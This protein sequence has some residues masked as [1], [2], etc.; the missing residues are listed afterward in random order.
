MA[1]MKQQGFDVLLKRRMNYVL[2]FFCLLFVALAGRLFVLQILWHGTYVAL[3]ARQHLNIQNTAPDRGSIFMQARDGTR[4]PLATSRTFKTLIASPRDMKSP[5][6]AATILVA[7][8]GIDKE[9]LVAKLSKPNDVYEVIARK[10]DDAQVERIESKNIKG[11]SFQEEKLRSYP[12]GALAANVVGFVSREDDIEKGR[13]GL[14]SLYENDLAGGKDMWTTVSQA[15]NFWSAIGRT[16]IHPSQNGS[17]LVLTLD[18]NIQ[19][20]A[21]EALKTVKEKWAADS[22]LIIVMDPQTGRIVSLAG[23]PS[24]DPNFYNKEKDLSVFLN[25]A[26]QSMFELGSVVKPITMAAAIEQKAVTS[27]TFYHDAGSVKFGRYTIRNFDEKTYGDQTMTQVIEK[28]LNLGMV[29]V[30]RRLGKEKE[31]EYFKR[32]G[33]GQKTGVDMMGEISG[34]IANLNKGQDLDYATAAFGQGI[35]V[36]PLQMALA[37]SAIANH[38]KLMKPY[39]VDSLRDSSGN[40]TKKYP[41]EVR[42][43]VSPETADTI[44]KMM[45]SAVREGYENKAGVSGYFIAGKTGTAQIP[46]SDGKGYSDQFIHTFVG[47]APAFDPKFLVLIQLNNPKGNRFAANTLT[48]AFHDMAQ[49]ILN[50]YEIPPD[51]KQN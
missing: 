28:S 4:V 27:T 40:E 21:E 16:I 29:F 43:V 18:Y 37:I 3:A 44:T 1:F 5:E 32:F 45:I 33:F 25:P 24:F 17:D 51:E 19:L 49:F 26:V 50:Y 42:T 15:P 35:A 47:Y 14:E 9:S 46:R 8:F 12:N 34:N 2:L 41:E 10:V 36:T 31:L 38:G 22:G 23:S 39:I 30:S 13:Y 6:E 48:P 20:K 7:E 11:L